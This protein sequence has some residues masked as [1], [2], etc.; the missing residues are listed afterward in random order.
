MSGLE[1]PAA[2]ELTVQ[3]IALVETIIKLWDTA[4]DARGLPKD[5]RA[6]ADSLPLLRRTLTCAEEKLRADAG[7]EADV[8]PILQDCRDKMQA[9]ERI[10]QRALPKP[11]Q[12]QQQIGDTTTKPAEKGDS[13]VARLGKGARTMWNGRKARPLMEDIDELMQRL[14]N[15]QL[16]QGADDSLQALEGAMIE[17]F[18]AASD[19]RPMHFQ[20]DGSGNQNVLTGDRA[21]MHVPTFSGPQA[22]VTLNYG[23]QGPSLDDVRASAE[24]GVSVPIANAQN[25]TNKLYQQA[26]D[27]ELAESIM[28]SLTYPEMLRRRQNVIDAHEATLEWV[29][30]GSPSDDVPHELVNDFTHWLKSDADIFWIHGK[31]GSGKSTF[32]KFMVILSAKL[33]KSP[34]TMSSAMHACNAGAHIIRPVHG[35]SESSGNA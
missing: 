16:F 31:P 28:H 9:L 22:R 8:R 7:V 29:F 20:N 5:M 27:K 17:Y 15:F 18:D 13:H 4:K 26:Q 3:I 6:V 10:F 21:V 30:D 14:A 34:G 23:P 12:Q 33:Q 32:M 19:D 2:L 25:H 11:K 1:V 35:R 24:A